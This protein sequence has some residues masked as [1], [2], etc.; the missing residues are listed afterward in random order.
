MMVAGW[1]LGCVLLLGKLSLLRLPRPIVLR[2]TA[3]VSVDAPLLAMVEHTHTVHEQEVYSS[4]NRMVLELT[5]SWTLLAPGLLLIPQ[6]EKRLTYRPVPPQDANPKQD[7]CY[8]TV[9]CWFA[10]LR[11][12]GVEYYNKALLSTS[13]TGTVL[14]ILF[15]ASHG[16][17]GGHC[18]GRHAGD[19]TRRRRVPGAATFGISGSFAGADGAKFGPRT[20][21]RRRLQ[22]GQQTARPV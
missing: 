5:T 10:S 2:S 16:R 12:E 18:H 1:L 19:W 7:L 3:A 15:V 8:P 22:P 13:T 9:F 21:G 20:T 14:D 11:F 6:I 17:G 4:N